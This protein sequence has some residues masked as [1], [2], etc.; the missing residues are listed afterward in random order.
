LVSM[1]ILHALVVEEHSG[2]VVFVF[3]A[4]IFRL[5]ID[6]RVKN[7]APSVRV[8]AIRNGAD[9]IS[10]MGAFAAVIFL[11]LSAITGYLIQPFSVLVSE[12]ILLN[13]SLVA[14]GAL[15]FWTA[16]LVLRYRSGASMWK[17]RRLYAIAVITATLGFGFTAVTGSIGAELSLGHSVM[18]PVYQALTLNLRAWTL[19]PIDIGITLIITVIGIVLTAFLTHGVGIGRRTQ[20]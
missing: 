1:T 3:A 9:V 13:K 18:D 4:I 2:I 12:P 8:R 16:F 19:Q 11:V 10:Y 17:K 20:S 7:S 15:F 6:L 5:L 14:L